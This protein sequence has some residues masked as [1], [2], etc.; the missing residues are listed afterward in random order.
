M[1]KHG[2]HPDDLAPIKA[3]AR[4]PLKLTA[5]PSTLAYGLEY[6]LKLV[7]PQTCLLCGIRL[8]TQQEHPYLCVECTRA[9]SKQPVAAC[10]LCAEPFQAAS[11]ITHQCGQCTISPP[12]FIWLKTI[13]L[14][15]DQLQHAI[16]RLKYAGQFQLAEALAHLLLERLQAEITEFNPHSIIPVPLHPYRLRSRGFNQSLLIA[17]RLGAELNIPMDNRH[18]IRTRQTSSQTKLNLTQRHQNIHGA[19]SI[20]AP[21]SPRRILLVDDVVTTTATCR[22]CSKTLTQAGHQVAVIALSRASLQP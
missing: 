18:L 4:K 8:N 13:G 11:A 16:Q 9:C 14:H 5:L 7:L 1:F 3:S 22:E 12:P 15:T 19:F 17:R 20:N 6:I 2:S 21:L 10:Q